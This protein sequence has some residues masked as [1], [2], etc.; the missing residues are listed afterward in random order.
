MNRSPLVRWFLFGKPLWAGAR[1][2]GRASARLARTASALPCSRTGQRPHGREAR[3][4]KT[5]FLNS[6]RRCS[7][8]PGLRL[9]ETACSD[10]I[11]R[12]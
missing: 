4:R 3:K 7:V 5:N 10:E 8:L 12:S 9:G 1:W 2:S 11:R 6:G